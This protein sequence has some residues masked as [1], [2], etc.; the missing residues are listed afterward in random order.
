MKGKIAQGIFNGLIALSL[1]YGVNNPYS[2]KDI[3]NIIGYGF[4]IGTQ[5]IIMW[6]MGTVLVFQNERP[7][8]L[9]EQ[10]NQLYDIKP[11]FATKNILE[12]PVSLLVPLIILLLPY[13]SCGFVHSPEIFFKMYLVMVLVG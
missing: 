9:R 2:Q 1:Y 4:M 8:F 12:L 13:W 10:A 5:Q 7:V 3:Q 6:T 11:Y